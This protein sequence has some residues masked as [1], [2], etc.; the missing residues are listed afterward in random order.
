MKKGKIVISKNGPYLVSGSLSLCKEIAEVGDEGEPERWVKGEKYPAPEK[1]ALCRCGQSENHPFCDG[2]HA[3]VGFDGTEQAGREPYDDQAETIEG[4]GID[5]KDAESLCASAGFCVPR[6]GILRLTLRSGD[7]EKKKTAIQ[8]A[9]NCPAG[10]LVACDKR[11]GNPIEPEFEPSI[12]LTEDPRTGSSGPIWVKGGV[13]IE[14]EDGEA[15]ET[16]NRV[17]L[18]RCGWSN[19][20]PFCD[21]NHIDVGFNDGDES[22]NG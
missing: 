11:T 1:Y 9:C 22:L 3:E 19:N 5:L 17:A 14:S 13:T 8:Q 18:C 20:K 4:P 15:Y 12:S 16:R 7:P 6:G 10:R 21:G 2:T